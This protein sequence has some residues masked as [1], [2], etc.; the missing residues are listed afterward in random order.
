M[1]TRFGHDFSR[2]RVHTDEQAAASARAVNAAAFT[3]GQDIVFGN[4]QF[5]PETEGGR[6]LLAHELA[7]VIQQAESTSLAGTLQ[8]SNGPDVDDEEVNKQELE[9]RQAEEAISRD[10]EPQV[11]PTPVKKLRLLPLPGMPDLRVSGVGLSRPTMYLKGPRGGLFDLSPY[12]GNRWL[13][14]PLA[15]LEALGIPIRSYFQF[16]YGRAASLR[17]MHFGNVYG[18]SGGTS[19]IRNAIFY[20][21]IKAENVDLY[22]APSNYSD[23]YDLLPNVGL[24]AGPMDIGTMIH[25][26]YFNSPLPD[27]PNNPAIVFSLV[28]PFDQNPL[29]AIR[30]LGGAIYHS[31]G[32][33]TYTLPNVTHNYPEFW[34]RP[35]EEIG[36]KR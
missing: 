4:G 31:A 35:E 12:T 10:T 1:E 3:V 27:R 5:A 32:G 15:A 17:G 14:F 9:A 2:V 8:K 20:G 13:D 22:G 21:Y 36:R 30:N 29:E 11:S 7:H 34:K 18:L 6:G 23:H 28:A 25:V 19:Y 33:R 26:D 16:H 24:H